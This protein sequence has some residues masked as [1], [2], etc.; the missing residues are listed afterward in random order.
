MMQKTLQVL[1]FS[2][3]TKGETLNY[4]QIIITYRYLYIWVCCL[5]RSAVIE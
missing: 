4:Y 1:I 2:D 3:I 5:A